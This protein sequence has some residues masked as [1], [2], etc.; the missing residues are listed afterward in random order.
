MSSKNG[1]DQDIS[2]YLTKKTR[3]NIKPFFTGNYTWIGKRHC[4]EGES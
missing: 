1:R 3:G 2:V 4:K